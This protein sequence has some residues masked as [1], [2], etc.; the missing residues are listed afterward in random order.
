M[1]KSS[2]LTLTADVVSSMAQNQPLWR[3][4]AMSI[5]YTLL[6]SK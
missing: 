4:L 3:L 6:V 1:T 2:N 5:E